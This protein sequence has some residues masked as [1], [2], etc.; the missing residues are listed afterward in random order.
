MAIFE[1]WRITGFRIVEWLYGSAHESEVILR[2]LYHS[3]TAF[4]CSSFVRRSLAF[5]G[6]S[7]VL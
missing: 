7:Q 1:N 3:S 2:V 4:F 6:L 5:F